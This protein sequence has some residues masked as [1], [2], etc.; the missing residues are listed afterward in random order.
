[1]WGI[2]LSIVSIVFV[3]G[4]CFILFLQ[5]EKLKSDLNRKLS[6]MVNQINDSQFYGYN[7]D[8]QQENNI[9]NVDKNITSMH[10]AVLNI[11]KTVKYLDQSAL[12]TDSLRKNITTE[13]IQTNKLNLGEY[14]FVPGNDKWVRMLDKNN[15][16]YYGG[17][18]ARNMW[19]SDNSYVNGNLDVNGKA[20]IK[21]PV[22]I[23]GELRVC[24]INGNNCRKI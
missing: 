3:I 24:D 21:G 23:N 18:A 14:S 16:D 1:M 5:H 17:L 15:S 6:S 13:N 22:T 12:K 4:T 19:V 8:K 11:Q 9:M 10:D 20:F 2:I 7:F